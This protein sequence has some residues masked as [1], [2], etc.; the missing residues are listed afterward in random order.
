MTTLT[1]IEIDKQARSGGLIASGFAHSNVHQACYELRMS[2]V[3]YDLTEGNKRIQLQH[4]QKVLI[5]PLHRVVLITK[6]ELAV[7]HDIV[8]RIISKGSLFSVGLL[9][10]STYA[11]PGFQGQIGIVTQNVSDKYIE[12]PVGESI[13]KVEFSRL[14]GAVRVPYR[15]QHGF[16]TQ[17]WPIKT[18][19][20]RSYSE[21]CG[22]KRVDDEL[23]EAYRVTP[24]ATV[25][26]MKF[27]Y[28][29]QNWIIGVALSSLVSN[30]VVL[31][32]ATGKFKEGVVAL[33]INIASALLLAGVAFLNRAPWEK[34]S[35]S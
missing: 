2:D 29:R 10:V 21:V 25:D 22:D 28:R 11:D 33:L 12:L 32:V 26:L 6:E 13:A 1:D 27:L 35:G 9:P 4:G 19:L 16:G 5:K 30:C 18:H 7:P 20:Q 3:Y 14:S 8:A 34:S 15:G 23:T 17:I 31:A 24:A